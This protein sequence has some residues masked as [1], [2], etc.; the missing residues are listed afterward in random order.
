MK[1]VDVPLLLASI[2]KPHIPLPTVVCCNQAPESNGDYALFFATGEGVK[3]KTEMPDYYSGTVYLAVS[4]PDYAA[5]YANAGL[6]LGVLDF[7]G[8]QFD[9]PANAT[10]SIDFKLCRPDQMPVS[11]G[12][13]KSGNIEHIV[14]FTV[15][16]SVSDKQ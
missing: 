10:Q 6:A 12:R 1:V 13:N 14:S 5:G 8:G 15:T 9:N 2:L 7:Q 16:L 4:N 11:F 3:V